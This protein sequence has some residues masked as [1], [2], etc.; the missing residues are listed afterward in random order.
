MGRVAFTINGSANWFLQVQIIESV[1][2]WV[3]VRCY[4]LEQL[5]EDCAGNC[6]YSD[7]FLSEVIFL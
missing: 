5:V 1:H 6:I 4:A 3:I 7:W 2:Y